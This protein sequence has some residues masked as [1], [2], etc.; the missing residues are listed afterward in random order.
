MIVPNSFQFSTFYMAGFVLPKEKR[1][2]I[3]EVAS[4]SFQRIHAVPVL[5]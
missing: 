5:N 3:S 4:A 1:H 2:P